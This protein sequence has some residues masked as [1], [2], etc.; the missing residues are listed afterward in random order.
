M[1]LMLGACNNPFR[2][3]LIDTSSGAVLNRSPEELLHNL[4]KAYREK[5]INIFRQLLHPDYRF[6]LLSSEYQQIGIDMD[7]DGRRDFWWGYDQEIEITRNMFERGSSDGN[8]PVADAIELRLQIPPQELW[9]RDPADGYEDY[10]V[11]PCYFDLILTYTISN[12]S[13]VANGV[14]CFYLI[15]TNGDWKIIIWRD[16]SLL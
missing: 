1:F 13:Y 11:I 12:S 8:L 16:E 3:A 4:E 10:L 15:E 6:E 9:E 2:P 14:A 5:N 7:G